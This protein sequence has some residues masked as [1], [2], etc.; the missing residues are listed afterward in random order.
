[1]SRTAFLT[2][3]T[4]FVGANLARAL[5]AA[6]WRVRALARPGSDRRNL[7]DLE[8]DIVDGDLVDDDLE[9]CIDGCEA[10]FHVAAHYSLFR[11]DR[12]AL[13]RSNVDGTRNVLRAAR[14]AGVARTVYTSSVAA[15][16]VRHGGIADE[17]FQSPPEHLIGS[18]KLSKYLAEREA[19]AAARAGQD[20]VIV[21]PTTPI[22]PW[23]RKPTPTGDIFVRFLSGRMW[24]MVDTGLNFVDV[25]DVAH[26][27]LLAYDKGSSG[28]RY[29]LGGENL[30]LRTLLER[31]GAQT[32]RRAP[33]FSVPL[34]LPLGVAWFDE[35]ILTR[36]GRSPQ[37]PI[38]GVRMSQESMYYDASKAKLQLGFRP[39]PIDGAIRTAIDW[40]AENDLSKRR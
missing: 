14:S 40:F 27:H 28:E 4:G 26:G 3:G 24:A 37:I 35:T 2:G 5:L 10:V 12:E 36:L 25:A 39:A 1:M 15:I 21:N 13:M 22:G 34:W 18:Y 17:T 38:D 6:G 20:V 31:V 23:D 32:G 9:R 8:L 16:G 19:M 30:P 33:R 29:I 11:K 7:A